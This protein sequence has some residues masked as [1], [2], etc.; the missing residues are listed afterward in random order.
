MNSDLQGGV[1][2]VTGGSRGFGFAIADNLI[3]HGARVGL[4]A[5]DA[6]S[7]NAAIEKLGTEHVLAVT[8]DVADRKQLSAA[9]LRIKEHFGR[10]DGLVNNAGLARPGAVENLIEEEVIIQ[11][12]TNLAG[13]IFCCQ[14]AIPLLRGAGNPRI[15]NISP[16]SAHHYDEMAHLSVYAAT[17]AAVERFSRDLRRELQVDGIGITVVRPGGAATDFASSWD[18]ERFTKALQAWQAQGSGMDMGMEALHV[19]EIV[20]Y[21]LSSPPGVAIDLLEVRPNA[22]S[23]KP[24][25]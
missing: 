5:R 19:A 22:R 13:T 3:Q 14:A 23:P 10:L 18:E 7:L 9:F 17:K 20:S 24:I 15:V 1:Y 16:A 11:I 2:I 12:N 4:L 6:V 21:C 25:I 8:A